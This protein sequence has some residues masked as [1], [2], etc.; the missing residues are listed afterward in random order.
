MSFKGYD[1]MDKKR[2]NG[3][4]L[5]EMVVTLAVLAILLSVSVFS[6]INWQVNMRFKQQNEYA[7]TI[8]VAAQ[9]QLSAYSRSGK[10]NDI[11]DD[12]TST[13]THEYK[14]VVD[15][16][17]LKDEE[18]NS[19][20]LSEVWYETKA[21]S[22]TSSSE[23]KKYQSSICYVSC[24]RGDY[25][26]YKQG[27]LSSAAKDRGAD[28]LFDIISSY[29]YDESILNNAITLEF[30]PEEGQVFAVC[31]SDID[32]EFVYGETA[33]STNQVDIS[34]RT[35]S[36]RKENMIGYYGVDTLARATQGG[37]QKPVLTEV[38]LNNQDTL[39][40]SFKVIKVAGAAQDM[41]YK[42]NVYDKDSSRLVLTL[43]LSGKEI[44]NYNNR[45]TATA[46]VTRY[47]YD[48]AGKQT[49]QAIGDYD[50][51]SWID[52]DETVRIVL[53]A[54][55]I[56]ATSLQYIADM[57]ALSSEGA[58]SASF[59]DTFSFHR[60]GVNADNI[61]CTIQGSGT[62]YKSTATKQSNG[63]AVYFATAKLT[64]DTEL[65]EGG[66][67]ET[68][69]YSYTLENGRHLYNVRFVEDL[70][71]KQQ[72]STNDK[73][74]TETIS[75]RFEVTKDIDWKKFAADESL[76]YTSGSIE[77]AASDLET[78]ITKISDNVSIA[79]TC[80]FPSFKQL[81]N[82]DT[83]AGN[84]DSGKNKK[85]KTITGLTIT[86]EANTLFGLYTKQTESGVKLSDILSSEDGDGADAASAQN[87]AGTGMNNKMA[88]TEQS[89]SLSA[90]DSN[91]GSGDNTSNQGNIDNGD[92]AED[93]ADQERPVG[94]FV[95]NYGTI[96]KL[97]L[98]SINVTGQ[99]KVGSFCG[100]NRGNLEYLEV[101]AGS[102]AVPS[103]ITGDSNVGGIMGYQESVD[104]SALNGGE[105]TSQT[106][107]QLVNRAKVTG[108]LYVGGI[109]GIIQMPADKK[110]PAIVLEKCE[111]YGA[112]VAKNSDSLSGKNTVEAKT[113]PRYLGGIVGYCD[114]EYIEKGSDEPD[115]QL[116]RIVNCTSSP[117][118]T[119]SDL[120]KY[121]EDGI[122][123]DYQGTYLKGV[124]VGGIVG[125]NHFATIENC[126]A[127]SD[128]DSSG[129]VFGYKYVGG[130]VGFNQGPASGIVGGD[131][132]GDNGVNANN[133]VGVSF[134]GGITGCN[135]DVLKD[136]ETGKVSYDKYGIIIPDSTKK[137]NVKVSDWEN[138][139]IVL[140][141]DSYAGGITGYNAGWIYNCDSKVSNDETMEYFQKTY[142]GDY[143]GGIAGYNNGII[144]KTD[145]VDDG[146]GNYV[147]NK[148]AE[149]IS[150]G[151]ST[152][153]YVTGNNYVGGIV[154]YNDTD[155]IVEDYGIAGGQIVGTGSFVG[156]YAGF[157]ASVSLLENDNGEAH[158][159]VSKPN[160][161]TG[162]YFVG[163]SIGG[164]I[165][166]A[167]S[168]A[169]DIH[170]DFET[171][172]FFGKVSAEAFAGGY[173]GYNLVLGGEGTVYEYSTDSEDNRATLHN[174][175]AMS[176]YIYDLQMK[177][178]EE[179]D[180]VDNDTGK[181]AT[182]RSSVIPENMEISKDEN[183]MVSKI[184]ILDNLGSTGSTVSTS[185]TRSEKTLVIS[186]KG[187][188]T[189]LNRLG[190]IT[191]KVYVGG[192]I[193][194]ND[195]DTI[196]KVE[197]VVNTTPIQA[198][199]AVPNI[200]ERAVA[201]AGEDGETD[202]DTDTAGGKEDV[203][204]DDN[205][206]EYDGAT[207]FT[208][209]Y[210]GGI[211]GK[212]SKKASVIKCENGAGAGVTN[213]GSYTGGLAEVNEGLIQSCNV[214]SMGV[215]S[216]DYIGG[217]CGLN[218]AGGTVSKCVLE[219]K[220]VSGRNYV[221][222]IVA[223][224]FGTIE[225]TVINNKKNNNTV[226]AVGVKVAG[227]DDETEEQGIAGG[228]AAYNAGSIIQSDNLVNV[229]ITTGGMYAGVVAGVNEGIVTNAKI[230]EDGKVDSDDYI[231]ISGSV[232]GD[233]YVGGVIGVNYG[234]TGNKTVSGYRNKAT[235]TAEYGEAGGII[236]SNNSNIVI[237][238]CEN[239]GTVIARQ[240]GNAGGITAENYTSGRIEK[241]VNT[242]AISS[243]NGDCGGIVARNDKN[244]SIVSCTVK[245][246][247]S[248][249][250][251]ITSREVV[252]GMAAHN[253]GYIG[254]PTME[255]V[256]VY[257]YTSSPISYIGIITGKNYSTGKIYLG[258]STQ[259]DVKAISG[260]VAKTYID[261]SYVGGVAG[262]N[263]G[264]ITA[265]D[266]YTDVVLPE[267]EED[268][269]SRTFEK[270]KAWISCEV[271]YVNDSVSFGKLGGVAGEN[272]GIIENVGV[273]DSKVSGKL[274]STTT[275]CGGVAGVSCVETG[276]QTSI[277]KIQN[278]TFDGDV[279]ASGSGGNVIYLGGIVGLNQEGSTIYGCRIGIVGN[280]TT[281]DNGGTNAKTYGYVGGIAGT[282][283]GDII[284]CDSYHTDGTTV[285]VTI[286]TYLG[287]V[288][289]VVG[290]QQSSAHVTGEKDRRLSTGKD[291]MV[292]Y[293][294]YVNDH[295][296]GGIVG[297]SYTN[298]SYE[299]I[300]NY[301]TAR[302]V[303][304][305]STTSHFNMARGGI[306]G[307]LRP[308]STSSVY[309]SY[310]YNYGDI[311]GKNS[312]A[313][314]SD[315]NNQ[316][317]YGGIIG[318][319][320]FS[321]VTLTSCKNYGTLRGGHY[322]GGM[323]GCVYKSRADIELINCENHGNLYGS[324]A[325]SATIANRYQPADNSPEYIIYNCSNTGLIGSTKDTSSRSGFGVIR[326]HN[327]DNAVYY[328]LCQ[329]YGYGIQGT[330]FAGIQGTGSN[331]AASSIF[332]C[333][334][335]GGD[336]FSG[337]NLTGLTGHGNYYMN[338]NSFISKG[339]ESKNSNSQRL[340]YSGGSLYLGTELTSITGLKTLSDDTAGSTAYYLGLS[341]TGYT[342]YEVG[343]SYDKQ[344]I[345]YRTWLEMRDK[346]TAYIKSTY[347]A[348]N[349]SGK[350]KL[351]NP[352]GIA[353]NYKNAAG[354]YTINWK[355]VEQAYSYEVRYTVVAS[356]GGEKTYTD[357]VVGLTRIHVNKDVIENASKVTIEVRAK[358]GCEN[359]DHYSGWQTITNTPKPILPT[360]Q[361]HFE[362]IYNGVNSSKAE[363]LR[364]IAVLDNAE[365]YIVDGKAIAK[366][367]IKD[368]ESWTID[369]TVGYTVPEKDSQPGK[370]QKTPYAYAIPVD[371]TKYEQSARAYVVSYLAGC[372]VSYDVLSGAT[373]NGFYGDT[374]RNLSYSITVKKR[375]NTNDFV[376]Y[377]TQEIMAYDKEVGA[378][379]SY[380]HGETRA[381]FA[382]GDVTLSLSGLPTDLT[383]KDEIVVKNIYWAAQDYI[384]Y[385]GHKVANNITLKE[386]KNLKDTNFYRL[387]VNADGSL[388]KNV[389]KRT[390]SIWNDD[391]SLV[392]GYIIYKN[393]DGTYSV[394]YSVLEECQAKLEAKQN[395]SV[396]TV[397]G[398]SEQVYTR[399]GSDEDDTAVYTEET[400]GKQIPIQPRPV[401]EDLTQNDD[402]EYVFTWDLD[403]DESSYKNA[404][405]DIDLV[406]ITIDGT[407]VALDTAENIKW[408]VSA[409][410]ATYT[411]APEDNWNYKQLVLTVS[412][413][414]GVD[415][416][417]KTTSFPSG[418]TR[419]FDI[420]LALS[421][422][423]VATVKHDTDENGNSNMDEMLYNII[424]SG[425]PT[426]AERD[427]LG[428]Y[429]ITV[430]GTDTR[431]HY[432]YVLKNGESETDTISALKKLEDVEVVDVTDSYDAS[433]NS[434]LNVQIDLNDY[435]SEE[436]ITVSVKAF[437]KAGATIYKDGP[438]G[439]EQVLSLPARLSVADVTQMSAENAEEEKIDT[440]DSMLVSV[441]DEGIVLTYKNS[442]GSSSERV[443][444]SVAVYDEK[445]EGTDD[446]DV[447]RVTHSG[448]GTGEGYWNTGASETLVKKS[449]KENMKG[450]QKNATY[451][452]SLPDGKV[453]SDYAGK[454][455]KIAIAAC[456]DSAITSFWSDEDNESAKTVNYKWIQIPRAQVDTTSIGEATASYTWMCEDGAWVERIS[457][458]SEYV[459]T[460]TLSFDTSN[461]SDEIQ[462]RV[463]DRDG[464]VHLLYLTKQDNSYAVSYADTL[465][466][467]SPQINELSENN[468]YTTHVADIAPGDNRVE[469]T[470]Y[471]RELYIEGIT[472]E[473][474]TLYATLSFDEAGEMF[475]LS[476]PDVTSYTVESVTEDSGLSYISAKNIF[477]Q[478]MAQDED[479]L[480]RYLDSQ[481]EKLV[482][483]DNGS[484]T[485]D[486][487]DESGKPEIPEIPESLNV[488]SVGDEE[489]TF[490]RFA[491]KSDSDMLA[492]IL[493]MDEENNLVGVFYENMN[494]DDEGE[495]AL[496]TLDSSQFEGTKVVVRFM[497]VG[498]NGL[499]D[500]SDCYKLD[501][502]GTLTLFSDDY[503]LVTDEED[504]T[505]EPSNSIDEAGEPS[506]ASDEE[507]DI[508]SSNSAGNYTGAQSAGLTEDND[509]R[510]GE[511]DSTTQ[512]KDESSETTETS[513]SSETTETSETSSTSETEASYEDY[514]AEW[515]GDFSEVTD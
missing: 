17:T 187:D 469:I 157:N 192:V 193:G 381:D 13:T 409:K 488:S 72:N 369:P 52:S 288:G 150:T 173:V 135:S 324:A 120:K 58:A 114:N 24:V 360:P 239:A 478:A 206:K 179:F 419:E 327:G 215:A 433:D 406:G 344:N 79:T 448:D 204:T 463:V 276:A 334:D 183:R 145:R 467:L 182:Y 236:G 151:V 456:S 254:N 207:Y 273:K 161:V 244:A 167:A 242:G 434:A 443:R 495:N 460:R 128:D 134:V 261:N 131:E 247:D 96:T 426:E 127:V 260:C 470:P 431:T 364:I 147:V 272:Q 149:T 449:A 216:T 221:G 228:I 503:I 473:T 309:I 512:S 405:Y 346:V 7:Q 81:K 507:N 452:I 197:N 39:N 36:Y 462:I 281:V 316:G 3:F 277:T 455:L 99:E 1:I 181:Y 320:Q 391:G 103:E 70:T 363:K 9:N 479:E 380:A 189:T 399:S 248:S 88:G 377:S 385:A 136:S 361:Y 209:S 296:V 259:N 493:V 253:E 33:S 368:A 432:F 143:A 89:A 84:T 87:E 271:G 420:K 208:Y 123:T 169:T 499:S 282:T 66:S 454:W 212:V 194:Y 373:F 91:E 125:Y 410:K 202:K 210:A 358:D 126:N 185:V 328:S 246:G 144:G 203:G 234:T 440:L 15:V 257:N 348:T 326:A 284:A 133:V 424:W 53:D 345:R 138:Q 315:Y 472:E 113:E 233:A 307:R 332:N 412:R 64:K 8:F 356:D 294:S 263:Q 231:V 446:S 73:F 477:V 241:C 295:A 90:T 485:F 359:E 292:S 168:E 287:Q 61:Y 471:S 274:G 336:L 214:S 298:N 4:T 104:D 188:E 124:Y 191:A 480:G 165:V 26:A 464:N 278:C 250:L 395:A 430:S 441:M 303:G 140:A 14:R 107:T 491:M 270:P 338:R 489:Y 504:N 408:D 31:F 180:N 453:W 427:D 333:F 342:A 291:W 10:L 459:T 354:Y 5:I 357:E 496:L 310:C 319:L 290:V 466:S 397:G 269:E 92:N 164:N 74:N 148:N 12:V 415:S 484:I 428:G 349:I 458:V 109:V 389:E 111:N 130:I 220:T 306:I 106:L 82:A 396:H 465:S 347:C 199:M 435:E 372:D 416:N 22:D 255:N 16:T 252:G 77:L 121:M 232:S 163:G 437:S 198:T 421:Q 317:R 514:P 100:S 318:Q 429:I 400:S 417:N 170:A 205:L 238:Y 352:T 63:E 402:G 115:T 37:V 418:A 498:E 350:T 436:E 497:A 108:T 155:A 387:K 76:Y 262:L 32:V 314:N 413:R 93:K 71:E 162:K 302:Y 65:V 330:S 229:K 196:L 275:G 447:T 392:D 142:S 341:D 251:E 78:N 69:S 146:S 94:L 280:G 177:L 311:I 159:I 289:G 264:T 337:T 57:E 46:S 201:T 490:L 132:N 279:T 509:A 6:L 28:V 54:A 226:N 47:V 376:A 339:T 184:E 40:L 21:V 444:L 425:V 29:I 137:L 286:Q 51:L 383:G 175:S 45:Q 237:S 325:A 266:W 407:E 370:G 195:E 60:F 75:N 41:D 411:I 200:T 158:E 505:S 313:E 62:N 267:G 390:Q 365:D 398:L 451:E 329:N 511:P 300:S 404:S 30:S 297:S 218:K 178:L 11:I 141:A 122:S 154:G 240:S 403:K 235:V 386:L 101:K 335:L 351:D 86:E 42:L 500:W 102:S 362:L 152:V 245:S 367:Q 211:L 110:Q 225:K 265:P 44:M 442:E 222:G 68:A 243:P 213:Q 487:V 378:V 483:N 481:I 43:N 83:F 506:G 308:E 23:A 323:I 299:Y 50:I 422:I 445:P 153:C 18:G 312:L 249:K 55:D 515:S 423:G 322:T 476:L 230:D 482:V 38:S 457:G 19:Y 139:G 508:Q 27:N 25:E 384:M 461:Q 20:D 171:N 283:Y 366:I 374:M 2:R 67:V 119:E 321:A 56:Q 59:A 223:D 513:E 34:D 355:T 301:A 227:E 382:T 105:F 217:I 174:G 340:N 118:Y 468:Q 501:K 256:Y 414:G 510:T 388:S 80:D 117:Q 394:Y 49:S 285:P 156:G 502:T 98:D 224:N 176:E 401:I 304:A 475:T 97:S 353:L 268:L 160:E 474:T 343:E 379:I 371:N 494:L 438:E 492:Q 305:V 375:D 35:T 85:N 219:D 331:M 116:I 48:S 190:Q 186:G 172:N 450:T 112:I 293:Y 439:A 258:I 95:T 166:D 393:A 486:T 129:Y